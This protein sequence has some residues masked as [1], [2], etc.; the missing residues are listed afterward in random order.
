M[1]V[2][3]ANDEFLSIVARSRGGEEGDDKCAGIDRIFGF[4]FGLPNIRPF[5]EIRPSASATFYY[6][7]SASAEFLTI[8]RRIFLSL[9]Y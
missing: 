8:R 1:Q 3:E 9:V 4:G 2:L 5:F 6:S 7:A